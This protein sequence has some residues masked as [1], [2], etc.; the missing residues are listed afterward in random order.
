[1]APGLTIA[2]PPRVDKESPV[3][4]DGNGAVRN[5]VLDELR[6]L[7]QEATRVDGSIIASTDGLILAH[8]IAAAEAYGV[9]PEGIAAL[10]AVN[11][12][13]SQRVADTA[14]H[15]TLQETVIR[16]AFGQVATY[17]AGDRALL[18][19]LVR[20][21]E[22]LGPLHQRARQTAERVAAMLTEFFLADPA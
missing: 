6:R 9:E 18:T 1:M 10:S 8:D 17:P 3:I 16:G 15:G 22:D 11:L 19:V 13:L 2:T 20:G 14:N 7:R 4:P 5:A 21:T 12:G